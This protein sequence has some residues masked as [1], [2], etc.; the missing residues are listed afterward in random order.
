MRGSDR[1]G[2][3]VT[4]ALLAWLLPIGSAGAQQTEEAKE[5][6]ESEE[7]AEIPRSQWALQTEYGAGYDTNANGST[8]VQS[9]LGF[10]LDPRYVATASPFAQAALTAEHTLTLTPTRGFITTV[11]ASHRLNSEASFADQ[12]IAALNTEGVIMHGAARFTASL[13][14]YASWLHGTGD[15]R[16]A[17]LDLNA[18]YERNA[19]ET[20]LTLRA[21]RID[22]AQADFADIEV[23]RYLAA[24]SITQG[25]IG[26]HAA[27]LGMSVVGGHDT[28]RRSESPFGNDRFGLQLSGGWQLA[29]SAHAYIELSG[30]RTRYGDRF[31]DERR[32]DDQISAATAVE[33]AGWPVRNWV[34]APQLQYVRNDSTVTLYEYD[35]LEAVIYVRRTW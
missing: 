25:D 15:E 32:T 6:E 19:I 11:Q 18:I 3:L 8:S 31:F 26:A 13:G 12:T 9:F 10:P 24:L 23:N 33:F 21:S 30:L 35:R 22:N 14:A 16:G 28:P 5:A 7:G 4:G 34:L 27:S 20:K 17:N 1:A 29:A 2:R